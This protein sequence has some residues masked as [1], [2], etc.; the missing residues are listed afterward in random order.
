MKDCEIT[1]NNDV[2]NKG[3]FDY[4]KLETKLEDI[5]NRLTALED[6]FAELRANLVSI[7][8]VDSMFEQMREKY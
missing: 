3:K 2:S 4:T 6:E 8:D 7:D 5:N 1:N